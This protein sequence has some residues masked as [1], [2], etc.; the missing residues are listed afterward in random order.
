MYPLKHR[1]Y[2]FNVFYRQTLWS[3]MNELKGD[4]EDVI[5]DRVE[6]FKRGQFTLKWQRGELSNF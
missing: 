3:L 6:G 1:T 2:F 5:D 4:V